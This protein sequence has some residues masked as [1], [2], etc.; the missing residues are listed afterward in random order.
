MV[1]KIS[2]NPTIIDNWYSKDELKNIFQELD[3]YTHYNKLHTSKGEIATDKNGNEIGSSFRI[4]LDAIY[5][6]AGRKVSSILKGREKLFNQPFYEKVLKLNPMYRTFPDTTRDFCFI[7]YYEDNHFYDSHPD[8]ASFSILIWLYKEPKKFNGG[9][10][11]FKDLDLTIECKNNRL[12]IFPGFLY[13][14]VTPVK[15]KKGFKIGDGRYTIT[16][17]IHHDN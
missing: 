1:Q 14:K 12:V 4:P 2:L 15:M 17:F 16:H 13:H 8:K 11:F 3:Y 5:T 9:D 10:L 6:E 7:S